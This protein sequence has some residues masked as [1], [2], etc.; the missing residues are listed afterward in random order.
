MKLTPA[1]VRSQRYV[2][3]DGVELYGLAV[4][5][6]QLDAP[7]PRRWHVLPS[8][9]TTTCTRCLKIRRERPYVHGKTL[10]EESR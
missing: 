1:P 9:T 2:V 10:R 8:N 6:C 5:R 3:H 7:T 4:A